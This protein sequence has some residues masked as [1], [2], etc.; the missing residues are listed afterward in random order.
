V[1]RGLLRETFYL[2]T[3]GLF[4]IPMIFYLR[5]T[6][7]ELTGEHAAIRVPLSFRSKNHLG[8]MYFGAL[9]IGADCAGGLLVTKHMRERGAMNVSFIFKDVSARFLKRA[10]GDVHFAC[11]DGKAIRK[12]LDEALDSGVRV[13]APLTIVA[14]VPSK[15]P[16]PVAE[17]TLTLSLK[18][19]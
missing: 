11:H 19:R 17:F 9:C 14:T 7:L 16:E 18:R 10:E 12:L 13:N 1:K 8:S 6:V 4:K 3:F 5:P 15:S 2:R